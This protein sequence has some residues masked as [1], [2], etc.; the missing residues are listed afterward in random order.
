MYSPSTMEDSGRPAVDG[1]RKYVFSK[2][3][4]LSEIFEWGFSKS[5]SEQRRRVWVAFDPFKKRYPRDC[6]LVVR[7]R[8]WSAVTLRTTLTFLALSEHPQHS[9]FVSPWVDG[10]W[11]DN[12][13]VG[14]EP[15]EFGSLEERLRRL[16]EFPGRNVWVYIPY[17]TFFVDHRK[18]LGTWLERNPAKRPWFVLDRLKTTAVGE[19]DQVAVDTAQFL[20]DLK[21]KVWAEGVDVPGIQRVRWTARWYGADELPA[22]KRWNFERS[23]WHIARGIPQEG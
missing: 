16:E 13:V 3:T 6:E 17:G 21:Q 9:W 20:L 2:T 18:V 22:E 8:L 5:Q 4:D 10:T 12:F 14:V 7:S 1:F 19:F 11:P 15:D 23:Q